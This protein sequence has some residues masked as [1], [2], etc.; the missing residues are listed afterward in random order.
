MDTDADADADTDTD[1][2]TDT[3]SNATADDT[4][5]HVPDSPKME[6]RKKEKKARNR[7]HAGWQASQVRCGQR[8]QEQK[9]K[10]VFTTRMAGVVK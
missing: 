7:H 2:D 8:N 5:R 6:T 1:T 10:R 4:M 3:H 9:K